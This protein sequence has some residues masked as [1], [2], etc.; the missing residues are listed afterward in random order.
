MLS[1]E[2]DAVRSLSEESGYRAFSNP[3]NSSVFNQ[4]A[5]GYS[6]ALATESSCDSTRQFDL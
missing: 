3:G 4:A 6:S 5:I 2:A 1:A